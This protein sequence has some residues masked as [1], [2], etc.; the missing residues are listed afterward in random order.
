V[1]ENCTYCT[2]I[3]SPERRSLAVNCEE[4]VV[5]EWMPNTLNVVELRVLD[6]MRQLN[7][8]YVVVLL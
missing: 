3:G 2:C 5:I 7:V 6:C 1:L 8:E 4:R